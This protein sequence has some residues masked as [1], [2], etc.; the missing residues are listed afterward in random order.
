MA[1]SAPRRILLNCLL[2]AA[3]AAL[4]LPLALW[5]GAPDAPPPGAWWVLALPLAVASLLLAGW[6]LGLPR[7]YWRF[8]GLADAGAVL[9]AAGLGA[10]L[11][12]AGLLL[13]GAWQPPHPAFPLLHLLRRSGNGRSGRAAAW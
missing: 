5:L 12:A 4:A 6:P 13:A 8:A 7:Q 9:G 2:D 3:L 11:F 1:K 10:L